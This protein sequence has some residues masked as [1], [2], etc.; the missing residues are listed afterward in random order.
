MK[1]IHERD[2][3]SAKPMVLCVSGI[4]PG[5]AGQTGSD[6]GGTGTAGHKPNVR[7]LHKQASRSG[8]HSIKSDYCAT[9]L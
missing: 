4:L 2:D 6:N 7:P 9:A 1:K 5:A 3:T 8:L